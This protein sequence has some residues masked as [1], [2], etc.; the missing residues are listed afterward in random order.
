MCGKTKHIHAFNPKP[1]WLN[2]RICEECLKDKKRIKKPRTN[3]S[4]LT[5]EEKYQR[6]LEQMREYRAKNR[7]YF[8]EYLK[9]YRTK[10]KTK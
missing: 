9:Y 2:P 3:L 7:E 10:N 1:N 4:H 5:E 8:V 6:K